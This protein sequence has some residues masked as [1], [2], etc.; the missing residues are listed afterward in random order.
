MDKAN[1]PAYPIDEETTD[2]I[3]SGIKIYTGL[4]KREYAAIKALQG[5]LASPVCLPNKDGIEY[6]VSMSI[7][8]ADE[9]FKQLEKPT[10]NG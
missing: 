9:L 10:N 2:R 1:K 5:L 4:T 6:A 7:K 8:A 3:D